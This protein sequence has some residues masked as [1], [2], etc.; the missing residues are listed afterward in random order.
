MNRKHGD[1]YP[2]ISRN[3]ELTPKGMPSAPGS[4]FGLC[5]SPPPPG[6]VSELP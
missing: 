1:R 6:Q 4:L 3:V 5:D 2:S